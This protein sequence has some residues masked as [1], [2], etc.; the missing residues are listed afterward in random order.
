M[1][2]IYEIRN[3]V[4]DKRY[5][6]RTKEPQKRK[7]RHFNDLKNGKHHCLYLQRSYDKHGCENFKFTI[8]EEVKNFK[9]AC[10]R[11]EFYLK[12]NEE[13]YN[14]SVLSSGGDLIS[15]HPNRA[16]IIKKIAEASKKTWESFS[17]EERERRSENL[18]GSKNPNYHNRG[19][20]SP[21]YK[22]AL[23]EIH[24]ENISKA[25]KG[26]KFSQGHID[27]IKQSKK[28]QIPWN[29]GKELSPL[30]EEHKRNLS[31]SLTGRKVEQ[32]RK[33]VICEGYYFECLRDSA[34]AYGISSA[35]MSVRIKSK[36]KKFEKFHY[37][38][39][40]NDSIEN[41]IIYQQGDNIVSE[42][43]GITKERQIYC[44]GEVLTQKEAMKKYNIK[45]LNALKYRCESDKEKWK[46]FYYI[47]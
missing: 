24:K 17:E 44:E 10:E 32:I 42:L 38:D 3:L 8:I 12:S 29:K 33:P 20:N 28:G 25:L 16:N 30:T 7:Y 14:T 45:S 34:E 1:N 6:G 39:E 18:K 37:F 2:Y 41:Y 43:K 31:K 46:D 23:S 22:V 9:E 21:L 27:K 47:N 5:I 15:Y 4:T 26:R 19:E 36:S 11:E 40:A 35:G 13:L